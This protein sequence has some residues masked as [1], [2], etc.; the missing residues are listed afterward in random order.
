MS[1]EDTGT[2]EDGRPDAAR[3]EPGGIPGSENGAGLGAGEP[4]TFEPEEGTDGSD[5]SPS[6]RTSGETSVA[7]AEDTPDV[8]ETPVETSEPS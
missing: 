6:G 8:E 1:T 7:T 5:S 3:Q 2:G 4:N